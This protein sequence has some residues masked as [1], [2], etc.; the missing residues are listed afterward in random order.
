MGT[1][2]AEFVCAGDTA[3]G[4]PTILP[5]GASS[6]RG[7][8]RCHSGRKGVTCSNAENGHGFF[9]SRQSFRVF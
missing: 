5:Y 8:F 6:R 1:D 7:D 3:L 4:A 2:R 9:L